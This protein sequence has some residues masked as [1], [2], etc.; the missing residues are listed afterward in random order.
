V[1]DDEEV[2]RATAKTSMERYGYSVLLAEDGQTGV[3]MFRRHDEIILVLLDMTMP[4]M[5]GQEAFRQILSIRPASRV[6][7]SSGYNEVEAIRRF[8]TKGISGFIQKP[9]TASKLARTVKQVLDN[10][11]ALG[12]RA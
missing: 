4:M 9:Y 7:I 12:S 10:P 6:I 11:V 2:V 8:T 5:S 3:D 1:I